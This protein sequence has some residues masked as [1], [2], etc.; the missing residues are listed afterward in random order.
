MK[1]ILIIDDEDI[2]EI[3]NIIFQDAG[4][5]VVVSNHSETAEH[6]HEIGPD[7]VILDIRIT[8]SDKTGGQICAE[9]KEKFK[10]ARLPVV[11]ISGETD[12]SHIAKK[13]GADGY[14]AKPFDIEHV[15]TQITRILD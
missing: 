2:L 10:N 11:L 6:I 3:F 8:G 1:R 13:C 7:L 9:I 5:N 12:I 15:L 14:I 4:Y